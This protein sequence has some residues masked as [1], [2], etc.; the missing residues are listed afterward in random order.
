M[1]RWNG[2]GDDTIPYPL[3]ANA[4][5]FLEEL[6]GPGA[7]ARDAT[8]AATLAAIPASRLPAHPLVRVERLERLRHARGQSLPDWVAL[9][10][11]LIPA[12]PDGVAF[13]TTADDVAALLT[14]AA[15]T[16]A[17][18]IPYGGGTS[19]VGHI[20]P[21]PGERPVLT[22][23]M[24]RLNQLTRLDTTNQLATFGAGVA[25][26]ELEAQLRARGYTLG[27]FPQSFEYST[28]GGWVATRSSG[29][30]SL[31]YGRIE[32]LFAGG[33]L[34]SPAG[35]L[36]LPSFPASAA[37]PDLRQ[38]ILGSEGRMGILTE[39]T[40]RVTPL[41]EHEEFHA[42]FFPDFASGLSATR[43][44]VQERLPLSLLRLS[45][46]TETRTTL[47]LAGHERL[48]GMLETLL[49][50]R[51]VGGEKCMLLAGFTGRSTVVRDTRHTVMDICHAGGGVSAGRRFGEQ[52]IEGRFRTPYLRNTLWEAGYAVDTL[53]TA[54]NWDNVPRMVEVIE[55]ALRPG[56]AEE[57]ERVHVFT[58]L[59]HVYPQGA[60]VYTTYLFR[61]A[62]DPE[63]TLRRWET[64]KG[65]ASRAIVACG[66]TISHQHGVGRDHAP[67]LGAEKGALGLDALAAA[68][69]RFDPHG[70]MN[71]GVLLG[72]ETEESSRKER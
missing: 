53:E 51:G 59:S 55:A 61:R 25:G 70:I 31:R 47:A 49:S 7:P 42:L 69:A 71:P 23:N 34:L 5:A 17:R 26:P 64:L 35:A 10:G 32:G 8:L 67:Y 37:G 40:V 11:G 46:P 13:P 15:E 54:T 14:Y 72:D 28:L 22:I 16:G 65:A 4:F 60:S 66:G 48:I 19:V 62:A 27:H 20:N 12:F 43:Q 3:P 41:P 52:W 21:A 6:V 2:W 29:Q 57:G 58:H 9:R 33:V 45:T 18:V 63:A 36:H 1:R 39:V 24:R 30:Q 38:L 56:L 68:I 44:I 50:V